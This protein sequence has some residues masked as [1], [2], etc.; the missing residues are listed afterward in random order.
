MDGQ[1]HRAPT[2]IIPHAT[3]KPM[4][5]FTIRKLVYFIPFYYRN[6]KRTGETLLLV[7]FPSYF[8]TERAKSGHQNKIYPVLSVSKNG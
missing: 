8:R 7:T 3:G 1:L 6:H 4:S 5:S 2:A